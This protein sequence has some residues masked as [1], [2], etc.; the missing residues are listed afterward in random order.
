MLGLNLASAPNLLLFFT[1]YLN[2]FI[3]CEFGINFYTKQFFAVATFKV[4]KTDMRYFV[5]S[6]LSRSLVH[7]KMFSL[8]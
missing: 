3:E 8:I 4:A 1:N 6:K 5:R 7:K 2:M